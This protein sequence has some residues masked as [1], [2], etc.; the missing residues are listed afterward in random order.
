MEYIQRKRVFA[1]YR[2]ST[3][4]QVD[5]GSNDI[6]MQEQ[7]CAK[8]C[9]RM[10]WDIVDSRS[11]KGVSGFK[12]SADDRDAIQDIREAALQGRFDVLLVYMFDRLGRKE[13]ET[14][15]I[16][17]WFVK[18]GVEVW[19]VVEGQQRF[20]QHID[21]LL[22]YIR[23]W[24]AEG[25]SEKTSIRVSTRHQQIVE[26]GHFRGGSNAF[27]YR[28]EH[29]GRLNKKGNPV[30]ELVIDE[31][32]AEI[33]RKVFS[34]YVNHGYGTWRICQYLTE[35][36]YTTREGK[37]FTNPTIQHM[38]KR[39]L[40]TGVIIC[41]EARSDIVPEL[42]IIPPDIFQRAQT[43]NQDR[44]KSSAERTVPQ[45]TRGHTLLAGIVY[46]GHCGARLTLTTNGKKYIR[47]DGVATIT[48]KIRYV[49][50]NKT[51]HPELCDGQTGY[52]A[53]KLDGIIDQLMKLFFGHI[54]VKPK[55]EIL[56]KRSAAKIAEQEAR[57]KQAEESYKS[58]QSVLVI[59]ENEV[60]KVLQGTSQLSAGLLN[61]KYA[62]AQ[63][64]AEKRRL[65]WETCRQEISQARDTMVQAEQEYQNLKDWA[66][67]Y[68]QCDTSAKKMIISQVLVGI[69]VSRDYR[70]EVK[71]ALSLQ[72][73]GFEAKDV[74][75]AHPAAISSGV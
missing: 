15:F 49:C 52:T 74:G 62:E 37:G 54:Q 75:V 40:Y 1:L 34:L 46:C 11:E 44:C 26:S 28:L 23:F 19:S 27:G 50:Y 45:D 48:P 33:V 22:N 72:Q 8:F 47:K 73:L 4:G 66:R 64:E 63:Q 14:P 9:E 5:K 3:A 67:L 10:G 32:E 69:K 21:K 2:V 55:G 6:P 56:K 31:K 12:V 59:L 65:E 51:R 43:I 60:L 41:R 38:I 61:K 18:H 35:H 71:S 24:Q 68:D 57:L 36:G 39:E 70:I 20:D 42:Q 16:L 7:A 29:Q 53:K 13:D 58:A 17:Q 25:E 30:K